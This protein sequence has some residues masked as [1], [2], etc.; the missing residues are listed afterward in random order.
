VGYY[1]LYEVRLFSTNGNPKDPVIAAAGRL[2]GLLAGWVHQHG[3][4][5]WIVAL[6]ALVLAALARTF[7]GRARR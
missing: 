1:G 5:P 2:Q 3:A 6:G 7:R 4:W